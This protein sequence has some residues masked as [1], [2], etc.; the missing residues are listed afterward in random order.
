MQN[1]VAP[2]LRCRHPEPGGNRAVVIAAEFGEIRIADIEF[3][4]SEPG[5]LNGVLTSV[6]QRQ[7]SGVASRDIVRQNGLGI[8]HIRAQKGACLVGLLGDP[9]RIDDPRVG[10]LNIVNERINACGH[11][12]EDG[13]VNKHFDKGKA[14]M[15][16]VTNTPHAAA[17]PA[18]AEGFALVIVMVV[19]AALSASAIP[20]LGTVNR[21][22]E[23]TVAQRVTARLTVEARENLELGVHMAKLSG[24]VPGYFTNSFSGD[25]TQLA[26]ACERRLDAVEPDLL[27]TGAL[28]L[29]GNARVSPVD[30]VDNALTGIFAIDKGSVE[31]SRY[32]RIL[33][34]GC[35]LDPQ[36]G[37]SVAASEMARIQGSFYVLNFTE[38]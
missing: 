24:G 14:S 18:Q 3:L 6:F 25:A 22:Q 13:E 29:T 20:L 28:S 19:I 11:H 9:H 21:N 16:S 30:S 37:I 34:V 23:S 36:F 5:P 32:D 8:L 7:T 26:T 31:D 10:L 4:A 17:R 35:A 2:C 27:R 12:A 15:D 1:P 33:I 38:Y